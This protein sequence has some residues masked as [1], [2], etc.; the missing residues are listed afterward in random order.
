MIRARD[1]SIGYNDDTHLS[2]ALNFDVH[3]NDKILIEGPSG[4]GKTTLLKTIMGEIRPLDGE[5]S[6]SLDDS[7]SF[8][9]LFALVEQTPF[10]FRKT[11]R[12]NLTLG[13]D[14]SDDQLIRILK[15]VGLHKYANDESLDMA[16]EGESISLSGGEK[17]HLG[18]ARALLYNK[19][20]LI[21]DEALSGLDNDSAD[22]LNQFIL[23]YPGIVLN[24]EHRVTDEI[25]QRYNKQILL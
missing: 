1:L 16:L 6:Y 24:I 15:S 21:V 13:H 10:V 18:V 7:E 23:D 12:F 4:S 20:I 25:R 14:V 22:L 11:L 17:K 9:Q 2:K 19:K 5:V 3:P 8:S